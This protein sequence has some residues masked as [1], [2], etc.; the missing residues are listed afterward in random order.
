M[1]DAVL[2]HHRAVEGASH[3]VNL[4]AIP[5]ES[6]RQSFDAVHD[7]GARAVAEAAR[8]AGAG[9]T[10]MSAIGADRNSPSAYARTKALG[11]EAAMQGM[12]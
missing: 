8:A 5:Y 3:V 1:V 10:H 4:V 2:F 11:E 7:F 12:K 9:L 6:G